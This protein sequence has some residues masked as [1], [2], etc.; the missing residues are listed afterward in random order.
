VEAVVALHL[1]PCLLT[2]PVIR[3][4][5]QEG[6]SRRKKTWKPTIAEMMQSFVIIVP[7]DNKLLFYVA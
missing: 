4:S 7:V 5:L 3:R 6:N 1:F 2:A